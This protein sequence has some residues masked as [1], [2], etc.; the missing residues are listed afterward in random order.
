MS[1]SEND[2]T[3][4]IRRWP[5]TNLVPHEI[6][7]SCG[8]LYLQNESQI[9]AHPHS[10]R[11]ISIVES[12][13]FVPDLVSI[14]QDYLNDFAWL[15]KQKMLDQILYFNTMREKVIIFSKN[16]TVLKLVEGLAGIQFYS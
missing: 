14:V 5:D 3:H 6:K 15:A 7:R 4:N 12:C 10:R 13:I 9:A 11:F 8:R 16:Y 1:Q 2:T